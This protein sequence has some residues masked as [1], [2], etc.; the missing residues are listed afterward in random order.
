MKIADTFTELC[1]RIRILLKKFSGS[2]S[3]HWTCMREIMTKTSFIILRNFLR[4]FDSWFIKYFMSYSGFH[5]ANQTQKQTSEVFY[6]KDVLKNLA[7]F[8][9]KYLCQSLF[10]NK[11]AGLRLPTLLKGTFNNY[12]T[13]NLPF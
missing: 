2:E 3:D 4:R 10:F 5:T 6:K 8:T 13:L 9:G 1:Y 11:V 12:V 7:K